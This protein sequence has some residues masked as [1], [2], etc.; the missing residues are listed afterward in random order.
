MSQQF[1]PYLTSASPVV[2]L[3]N[4][5]PPRAVVYVGAGDGRNASQELLQLTPGGA[6]LIEADPRH[7][8]ALQ[9]ASEKQ[10][11]LAVNNCIAGSKSEVTFHRLSNLRESGLVEPDKLREIWPNLTEE[12]QLTIAALPLSDILTSPQYFPS[13]TR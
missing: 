1:S 10:G 3:R 13:A 5:F 8:G 11:W 4:L 6:L 7:G 12:E 9:T 2:A